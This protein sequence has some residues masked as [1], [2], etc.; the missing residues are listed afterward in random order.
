MKFAAARLFFVAPSPTTGRILPSGCD[1][2]QDTNNHLENIGGGPFNG[3]ASMEECAAICSAESTCIGTFF[4]RLCCLRD[5]CGRVGAF[6][7]DQ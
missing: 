7:F 4:T 2:M 1:E 6:Y 5:E 3:I